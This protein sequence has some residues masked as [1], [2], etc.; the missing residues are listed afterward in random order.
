MTSAMAT[1]VGLVGIGLLGSAV[2]TRLLKDGHRM[3][4]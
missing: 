2:A 3:V 4:A 1:T